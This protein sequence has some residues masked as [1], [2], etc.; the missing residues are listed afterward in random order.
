MKRSTPL[1]RTGFKRQ[2]PPAAA[3]AP[4]MRQQ[5]VSGRIVRMA[6]INDA[7]FR[8]GAPKTEPQRNP[9]L[10]AMARGQRC[11][12]QVPGV[13][14]PDPTT[15]VACHSNQS[16]HGKAGARKA[17]DHWHVHG[18]AACH[19]WL[20][21]G[22]APATEKIERF[23]AAHRWMVSIWQDIVAGMRSGTPREKA[24]ARWALE[25][26]VASYKA[27]RGEKDQ[28]G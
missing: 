5:P 3:R 4:L 6:A 10:L 25:R 24:A 9:A 1:R 12:L 17:D 27:T 20:D 7:E 21:Q 13:C 15:T 26:V 22:P 14:Q 2:A 11:L 16:V 8:G 23:A 18:C 19:R 28:H